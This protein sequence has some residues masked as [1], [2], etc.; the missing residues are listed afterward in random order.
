VSEPLTVPD[1][2][3]EETA[4]AL[5]LQVEWLTSEIGVDDSFFGRLVGTDPATLGRWR[6]G[7]ADLPPD[8]EET[9]R[10]LWRT[11]LHLLSFL[12]LDRERVRELFGQLMPARPPGD[13][14]SVSPPWSGTT[15]RAY[16][17]RD[18][19][20]G[21]EAVDRWVTGLRFGDPYAA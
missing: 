17:E 9:L 7:E 20:G 15:L 16:L 14:S 13:R 8:G 19:A 10:S 2:F 5:R 1:F 21:I 4:E 3:Q 12:N 6:R 11:M 18:R